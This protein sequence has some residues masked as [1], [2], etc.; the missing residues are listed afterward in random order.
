MP[1]AGQH[2]FE[3]SRSVVSYID[4]IRL[5][6]DATCFRNRVFE[7]VFEFGLLGIFTPTISRVVLMIIT[8]EVIHLDESYDFLCQLFDQIQKL[9]C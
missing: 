5:R 9:V 4:N 1:K 8:V 6:E 2:L 3:L 7:F